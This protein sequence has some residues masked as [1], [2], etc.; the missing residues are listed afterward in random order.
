[1]EQ[2]FQGIHCSTNGESTHDSV[3]YIYLAGS[4]VIS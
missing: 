2:N 1:M 4:V 3:C